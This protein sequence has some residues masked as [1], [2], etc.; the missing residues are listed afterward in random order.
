MNKNDELKQPVIVLIL[1]TIFLGFL[2]FIIWIVKLGSKSQTKSPKDLPA[3]RTLQLSASTGEISDG[4]KVS[5]I[6]PTVEHQK[7]VNNLKTAKPAK[8]IT[9]MKPTISSSV[10]SDKQVST[11]SYADQG[12]AQISAKS[13]RWTATTRYMA[14]A[15][16]VIFIIWIIFFSRQTLS[17][18]IFAALIALLAQPVIR[19]L[20]KRLRFSHSLAVVFTYLLVIGLIILAIILVIPNIIQ[21]INSLLGYNWQE[22]INRIVEILDQSADSISTIPLVGDMGANFLNSLSDFTKNLAP[23]DPNIQEPSLSAEDLLNQIE[24]TIGF[25][26]TLLGPLISAILSLILMILI[27]MQMSIASDQI[28]GWIVNPVPQR[29][30]EEIGNLI[31]RVYL[32]WVSF[33]S[34]QFSLMVI[35]GFLVWLMNLILGT[36][37]ALL[38]GILAGLL[39]VIPSIGPTLAAVP[40]AILALMFGS[41]NFPGLSPWIFMLIVILGYVL[42]NLV[43][44]QILVP[45]VLGDAVSLPPL[46]VI[47]GVTIAGATA[48]IAGI[49]LATPIIATGREL[50]NYVYEKIL[51]EPDIEPPEEEK[52]SLVDQVR[53]FI[54]RIPIPKIR[55]RK[56][57]KIPSSNMGPVE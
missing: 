31:D 40:A 43:E 15:G 17:L 50:F 21:G 33:L 11:E 36:P 16:I 39:E 18:L 48:G 5:T 10:P 8:P 1:S 22:P 51:E 53:S 56:A 9:E 57:E 38:L 3:E 26:A 37:Q 24:K 19:F 35:M 12:V 46:I 20:R 52:P 2:S 54:K 29:F 4:E 47:I 44:N 49:F 27:S 25:L 13:T 45:Q 28:R 6:P 55:R 32:V 42:L 14:G 41:N 30:K 34:G 23:S 7:A